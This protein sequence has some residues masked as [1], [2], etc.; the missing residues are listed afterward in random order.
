M[1]K[2]RDA[3][4]KAAVRAAIS[5]RPKSKRRP[6]RESG[7]EIFGRWLKNGGLTGSSS[8]AKC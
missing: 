1:G 8:S 7:G 6:S 3:R 4:D 5:G 2:R